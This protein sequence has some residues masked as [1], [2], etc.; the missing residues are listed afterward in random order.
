MNYQDIIKRLEAINESLPRDPI[1]G[2]RT[3]QGLEL[4]GLIRELKGAEIVE[5]VTGPIVE[6]ELESLREMI[7]FGRGAL[8]YNA[9]YPDKA[10]TVLRLQAIVTR[11]EP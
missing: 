3:Q 10:R 6:E 2:G 5:E 11:R 7:T 1:D 4:A 8:A 9:D